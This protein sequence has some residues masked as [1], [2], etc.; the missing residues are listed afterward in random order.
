MI[1]ELLVAQSLRGASSTTLAHRYWVKPQLEE[2]E[3][4]GL[5]T[6]RYDQDGDFAVVVTPA[7]SGFP[8]VEQMFRRHESSDAL[9]VVQ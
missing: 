3:E 2:L 8:D 6:W 4:R 9:E 5:I 1:V 7:F